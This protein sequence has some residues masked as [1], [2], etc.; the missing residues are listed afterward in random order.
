MLTSD[1]E[2]NYLAAVG[3]IESLSEDLIFAIIK[4]TEL[5]M[6]EPDIDAIPALAAVL[7]TA[8]NYGIENNNSICESIGEAIFL[9]ADSLIENIDFSDMNKPDKVYQSNSPF[10]GKDI[11][12]I[13]KTVSDSN[14]GGNQK[15]NKK[16]K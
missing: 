7:M 9:A 1:A 14:W 8:V 12:S 15:R 5:A 10:A 13:L 16:K 6:S 11:K 3:D 2:N 4:Y